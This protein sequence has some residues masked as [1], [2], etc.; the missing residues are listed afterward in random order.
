MLAALASG[1]AGPWA[2]GLLHNLSGCY[3]I[4]FAIGI[5]VSVL[6]AV[7]IWMASPGKVRGSATTRP[8]RIGTGTSVA[9]TK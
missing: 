8:G 3:T 2:T 5:V 4:A 7:A 6:S 9:L 1:A